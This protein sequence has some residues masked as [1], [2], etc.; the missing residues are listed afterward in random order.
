MTKGI[1]ILH[2]SGTYKLYVGQS[3]HIESRFKEHINELKKGSHTK[4]MQEAYSLFG[5]PSLEI[6][7]IILNKHEDM[8]SI[9][10][11]YIS[12]WD[13]VRDGFNTLATAAGGSL[14]GENNA[15]ALYSD[16]E[17]VSILFYIVNNPAVSLAEISRKLDI[18]YNVV[19]NIANGVSHKWLQEYYPDE[20]ICMLNLIGTR[21]NCGDRQGSSTYSNAQISQALFIAL[22]NPLLGYKQVA[23]AAGV[24]ETVVA[25]LCT[26]KGYLW[27]KSVY[28]EEHAK[29]LS[30]VKTKRAYSRSAAARGI[31]YPPVISPDGEIHYVTN[32]NAFSKLRNLDTGSM[33]R[34]LNGKANSVKGWKVYINEEKM[35]A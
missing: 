25:Q 9:E 20:Y 19:K 2:F 34:L 4:K 22:E 33:N 12:L 29:V 15:K 11:Y 31:V 8:D 24:T 21:S 30:A 14:S 16:K 28:P 27:L 6:E 10:N 26:G 3:L 5:R 1:Y 13:S 7:K 23:E 17:Y 35:P 32:V 18:S